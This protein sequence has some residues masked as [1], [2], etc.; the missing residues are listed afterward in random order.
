MVTIKILRLLRK[1]VS[2]SRINLRADL[3]CNLCVDVS[4]LGDGDESSSSKVLFVYFVDPLCRL[5]RRAYF[6][7]NMC[8]LQ[9]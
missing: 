9:A 8:R 2:L 1:L 6:I 3:I 5:D 4:G 7:T